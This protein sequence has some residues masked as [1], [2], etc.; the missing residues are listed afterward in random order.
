MNFLNQAYRADKKD[1]WLDE[2]YSL[3]RTVH[4]SYTGLLSKKAQSVEANPAPLDYIFTKI[5][6]DI[7]QPVNSFGFS[8]KTYYRLWANFVT[9]FSGFSIVCLFLYDILRSKYVLLIK[10]FQLVLLTFLPLT[11]L[12]RP[13]IYHYAAEVRPYA[14]WCALWFIAIGLCFSAQTKKGMLLIFLS[15]LGMT[16]TGSVFQILAMGMAYFV[17][18]WMQKGW[19]QALLESV[20][21]FTIPL[22]LVFFYAYPASYGDRTTVPI[23]IAW[24]QFLKLWTHETMIIPMM[25]ISIGLLHFSKKTQHMVIGPLSVLI[26]FLMGPAIFMITRWRGYFF[27][28]R[29]YIYYDIHKAVFLLCLINFLP[30]YLE[31]TKSFEN[32]IVVKIISLALCYLF[33]PSKKN[34]NRFQEMIHN[35]RL[36]LDKKE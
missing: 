21:I 6:D 14:L 25:L 24:K 35:A 20:Q 33:V 18:T 4:I 27:T 29:Q 34:V 9:V 22:L 36:V 28:E 32:R 3:E 30:I 2:Q 16:M 23:W 31:R 8:D 26:V 11:Y 12:F 10:I 7:K 1:F 19:K 13:M 5:F 17:V 15:L